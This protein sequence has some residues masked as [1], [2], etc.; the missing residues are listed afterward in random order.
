MDNLEVQ[1]EIQQEAKE[2][3]IFCNVVDLLELC[4]FIV[5]ST[6]RKGLLTTAISTSGIS[7]AISKRV[8]EILGKSISNEHILCIEVLKNLIE[9]IDKLNL[10]LE[11]KPQHH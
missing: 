2:K 9:Q 1:K 10:P 11:E 5:P 3:R 8:R 4:S 7:P 6:L